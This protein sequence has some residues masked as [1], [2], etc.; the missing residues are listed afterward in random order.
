MATSNA[1]PSGGGIAGVARCAL[2][3][4]ALA[5]ASTGCMTVD[6]LRNPAYDGPRTYSGVRYDLRNVGPALLSFS[7]MFMFYLI[8]LPLSVVGDTLVL[9]VTIP[10]E[11]ERRAALAERTRTDVDRPALVAS[12]PGELP[13]AAARRLFEACRQRLEAMRDA[14]A[15]CIAVDA[16]VELDGRVI[17]GAAFKKHLLRGLARLRGSGDFVAW[18]DPRFET[19]ADGHVRIEATRAIASDAATAALVLVVG[20]GPDGGWRVL[21]ASGLDW[22]GFAP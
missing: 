16:R 13:A 1:A 2:A 17:D 9:P 11:R 14:L 3:A 12:V 20:P 21:E 18:R 4:L 8:D 5:G 7:P 6:T 15:D 10:R 22:P 19:L